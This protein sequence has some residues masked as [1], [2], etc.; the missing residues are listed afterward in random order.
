MSYS[1]FPQGQNFIGILLK[2]LRGK[3]FH[4]AILV[5]KKSDF[6]EQ[7]NCPFGIR[8]VTPKNKGV[9]LMRLRTY[10][11]IDYITSVT[12]MT[13]PFIFGF[14]ELAMARNVFILFGLLLLINSLLTNYEYSLT[15]LIPLGFH[16]VIN[17][18]IG[19]AIYFSPYFLGYRTALLPSQV[20]VHIAAG[21]FIITMISFSRVK[22]EE[23]KRS[24]PW[25]K[26]YS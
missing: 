4:A 16:M 19:A 7:G 10:N 15:K 2:S 8:L 13:L 6:K 5:I 9:L 24:Y 12:L 21:L 20:L 23:D 26:K 3:I 17:F 25:Q 18:A 22:T 1:F 14:S 11:I